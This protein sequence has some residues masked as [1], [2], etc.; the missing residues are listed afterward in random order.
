ML[1][2]LHISSSPTPLPILLYLH[3]CPPVKCLYPSSP[4]SS[5]S[6][7]AYRPSLLPLLPRLLLLVFRPL[8]RPTPLRRRSSSTYPYSP[9]TCGCFP[10]FL[11]FDIPALIRALPFLCAYTHSLRAYIW[12]FFFVF[13]RIYPAFFR[14]YAHLFIFLWFLRAYIHLSFA[15]I[16]L[17]FIFG[18]HTRLLPLLSTKR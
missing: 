3:S 5:P 18:L 13:T 9:R 2:H 1:A 12:L 7:A 8:L 17:S 11:S 4:P 10:R 16:C 15:Y 6:A 14:C